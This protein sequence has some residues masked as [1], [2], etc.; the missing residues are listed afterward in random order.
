VLAFSSVRGRHT[1]NKF[2]GGRPFDAPPGNGSPR[3]VQKYLYVILQRAVHKSA[4]AHEYFARAHSRIWT[5]P[6]AMD[7]ARKQLHAEEDFGAG[8]KEDE[9]IKNDDGVPST[10]HKQSGKYYCKRVFQ[11]DGRKPLDEKQAQAL[12]RQS[13]FSRQLQAKGGDYMTDRNNEIITYDGQPKVCQ[14]YRHA[15]QCAACTKL[16]KSKNGQFSAKHGVA[17][18]E[19]RESG[20]WRNLIVEQAEDALGAT[21][22]LSKLFQNS[23]AILKKLVNDKLLEKFRNLIVVCGPEPRLINLFKSICFVEGHPVRANQEACI[24]KL[25][26]NDPDRNARWV[27]EQRML[28]IYTSL[29]LRG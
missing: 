10:F 1:D 13:S 16:L 20:L 27:S 22:T 19:K 8:S 18:D 21:V 17:P 12:R 6:S 11:S 9:E 23:K 24:R 2:R 3:A 4:E 25:W 26:I 28:H 15:W 7:K 5:S 29:V 14:K